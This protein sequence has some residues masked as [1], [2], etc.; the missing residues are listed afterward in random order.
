MLR[1][2]NVTM[3]ENGVRAA[4]STGVVWCQVEPCFWVG[5]AQGEFLGTVE[6]V[7]SGGFLARNSTAERVGEFGTLARARMAVTQV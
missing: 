7:G 4:G 3:I 1:S 6:R 5:N 2:T